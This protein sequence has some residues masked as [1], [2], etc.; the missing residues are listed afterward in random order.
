MQHNQLALQLNVVAYPFKDY[1][2][3]KN[4]NEVYSYMR[5]S[6]HIKILKVGHFTEQPKHFDV[7]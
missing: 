2:N 6:I 7:A 5:S 1:T 4:F 3:Q